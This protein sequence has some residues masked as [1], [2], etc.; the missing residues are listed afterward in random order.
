MNSGK[1]SFIENGEKFVLQNCNRN[2]NKISFAGIFSKKKKPSD[3]Q[4]Q[5]NFIA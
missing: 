5:S 3:F 2:S 1:F 4:I